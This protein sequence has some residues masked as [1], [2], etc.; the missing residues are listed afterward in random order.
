MLHFSPCLPLDSTYIPHLGH[1]RPPRI[2]GANSLGLAFGVGA[3]VTTPAWAVIS[4]SPER[5]RRRRFSLVCAFTSIWMPIFFQESVISSRASAFSVP[6]PDVSTA[7][8][9]G[10]P[11]GRRRMPFASRLVRPIS[12][13]SWLAS[14]GSYCAHFVAYPGLN[15]TD[16]D[17]IVLLEGVAIPP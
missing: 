6:S 3:A 16:L 2:V 12:S 9:T 7:R 1:C 4:A 5:V 15:S 11:S 8:K 14:S 17:V 13:N 10:R